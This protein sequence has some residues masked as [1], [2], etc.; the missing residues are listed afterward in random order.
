LTLFDQTAGDPA[1]KGL[2]L[3]NGTLIDATIIEGRWAARAPTEP[4]APDR[5]QHDRQRG[6]ARTTATAP[7][8]RPTAVA[9]SPT[10]L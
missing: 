3:N 10:Y 6:G 1:E 7:T 8:S 4:A 9:S 5:G 2:V